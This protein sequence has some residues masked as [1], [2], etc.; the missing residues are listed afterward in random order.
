[1]HA[2]QVLKIKNIYVQIYQNSIVVLH[3]IVEYT[4]QHSPL[5]HVYIH[6]RVYMF[7]AVYV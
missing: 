6:A 7:E 1:M 2:W 5:Y 4:L 3:N